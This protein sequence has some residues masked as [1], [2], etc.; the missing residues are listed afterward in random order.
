MVGITAAKGDGRAASSRGIVHDY[1]IVRGGTAG[2]VIAARLTENPE[3]SVLVLEA[4]RDSPTSRV[5]P[6]TSPSPTPSL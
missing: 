6:T 4:G 3:V 2:A 1:V 5:S